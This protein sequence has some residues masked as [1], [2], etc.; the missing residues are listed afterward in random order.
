[1]RYPNIIHHGALDGVTGSCHELQIGT[2][3]SLLIDCGLFQGYEALHRAESF[4]FD[5]KVLEALLITHV[6]IDHV[7]RLP[8]LMAAGFTG[9]ILCSLPSSELLPIVLEDALRLSITSDN[10]K[11]ERCIE[12]VKRQ[13]VGLAYNQWHVITDTQRLKCQ[14]RLQRAGHILGSAYVECDIS[15]PEQDIHKRVVFSGDLGAHDAPLLIPPRPPERADT[16]VLEST[17]GD[18]LH[19]DRSTRQERLERVIEKAL[20][21]HG[22][23]LIP[24]FSIG[25]TQELLYELE[26]ILH[27][28]ALMPDASHDEAKAALPINWPQL[29]V[30][31]DAP[32]AR[33]FTQGYRRLSSFW[34]DESRNRLAEGR[35]PLAFPQLITIETHAD[36]ERTAN[37]LAST[38]RPAIVIAGNGMCSGGRIVNYLKK[39][40]GDPRHHVV[41]V[42]YQAKGTPG[43][44]I[45]ACEGAAHFVDIDL[46]GEMHTVRAGVSTLG[47]YS[48]HADQQGLVEFVLGI[49][50]WP[51][52]IRLVHGESGAKNALRKRLDY[53]KTTRHV[54]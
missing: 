45:Q 18:R 41:F 7:G 6:H 5:I 35:K 50:S 37:Y 32:L 25:R 15:Y 29:P 34:N 48:A 20:A 23:V 26:D 53:E 8:Q 13:L 31:L 36:H 42:G 40:L 44:V 19:Q 38:G 52:E 33:R 39:M 22:T 49:P 17:Y 21:N 24:A 16:L 30:I 47:G 51:G 27:R 3:A 14:V 11:I 54:N 46:D 10:R 9:P 2:D 43:A 28:K 1:M 12:Q 4:D